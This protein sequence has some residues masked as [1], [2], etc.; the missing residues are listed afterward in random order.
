MIKLEI[1]INVIDL[2][3]VYDTQFKGKGVIDTVIILMTKDNNRLIDL[4][5]D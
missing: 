2:E 4:I 5:T 3:L 1:R